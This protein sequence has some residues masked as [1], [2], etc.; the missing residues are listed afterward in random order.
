MSDHALNKSVELERRLEQ[1]RRILREQNDSLTRDRLKKLIRDLEE[2]LIPTRRASN[3]MSCEPTADAAPL[4]RDE[5]ETAQPTI[6]EP[7]GR[8]KKSNVPDEVPH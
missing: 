6:L 7:G 5:C 2:Q 4:P 3:S 8:V 1:A